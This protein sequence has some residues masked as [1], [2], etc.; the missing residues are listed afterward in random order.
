LQSRGLDS[1]KQFIE[2]HTQ[3]LKEDQLN[4]ESHSD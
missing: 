2:R 1:T 3:V 4:D